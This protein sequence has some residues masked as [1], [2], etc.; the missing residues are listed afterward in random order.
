MRPAQPAPGSIAGACLPR[1]VRTH[2][3]AETMGRLKPVDPDS[4]ILRWPKEAVE[5]PAQPKRREWFAFA[6]W[7]VRLVA[8]GIGWVAILGLLTL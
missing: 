2:G 1:D 3:K 4:I 6:F 5:P 7:V 8:E